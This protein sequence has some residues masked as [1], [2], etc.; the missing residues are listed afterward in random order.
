M[1]LNE[2]LLGQPEAEVRAAIQE[3]DC[4]QC[5]GCPNATILAAELNHRA[6]LLL[7]FTY[8]TQTSDSDLHR[9]IEKQ[10]NDKQKELRAL[11]T[12]CSGYE[13]KK[14]ETAPRP[15][16]MC[17]SPAYSYHPIQIAAGRVL[18]LFNL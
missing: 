1:R 3:E 7:E 17:N 15:A 16:K 4:S 6:G 8:S 9:D 11:T 10:V 12:E 5:F 13:D 18:E 14:T 2:L